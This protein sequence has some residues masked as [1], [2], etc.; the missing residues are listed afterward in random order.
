MHPRFP[1][2]ARLPLCMCHAVPA[3]WGRRDARSWESR[4][5]SHEGGAWGH[6]RKPAGT[7]KRHRMGHLEVSRNGHLTWGSQLIGGGV[8][9]Q[10]FEISRNRLSMRVFR[11]AWPE[12]DVRKPVLV[13]GK[14]KRYLSSVLSVPNLTYPSEQG[15]CPKDRVGRPPGSRPASARDV[16]RRNARHFCRCLT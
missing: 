13:R 10:L 3:T 1:P 2:P 8:R 15:L 14:T 5:D 4:Q 9:G 12:Q 6:L 11:C 16:G 7:V